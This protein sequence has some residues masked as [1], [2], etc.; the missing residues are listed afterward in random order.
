[1][2]TKGRLKGR[3]AQF[4]DY[5][6][7]FEQEQI[8]KFSGSEVRF[9]NPGPDKA[10]ICAKCYHWF[11]NPASGWTPCEIMR[12]GQKTPVPGSGACKFMTPDG[13]SYPLLNV[14]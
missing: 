13:K 7:Y 2:A 14:L 9:T 10:H 12:L 8:H 3:D 5:V 1:M 11:N 6:R 4:A